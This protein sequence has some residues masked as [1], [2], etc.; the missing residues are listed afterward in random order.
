MSLSTLICLIFHPTS[1][2]DYFCMILHSSILTKPTFIQ[3]SIQSIYS[4]LRSYFT[5]PP[6]SVEPTSAPPPCLL[7]Q[8]PPYRGC[9]SQVR[10]PLLPPARRWRH[11][12][13]CG[14]P[15][16][17]N[18][19]LAQRLA[20]APAEAPDSRLVCVIGWR[21]AGSLRE[22]NCV[23][24]GAVVCVVCTPATKAKIAKK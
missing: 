21:P 4:N 17:H 9:P 6:S 11:L 18:S 2:Q 13:N 12:V 24:A 19:G 7:H 22:I 15:I 10:R 8:R 14:W 1:I 16:S 5:Q 3:P 20:A 23:F